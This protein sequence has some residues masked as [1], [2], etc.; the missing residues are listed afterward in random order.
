MTTTKLNLEEYADRKVRVTKR[1]NDGHSGEVLEGKV[2]AAN[3]EKN[4]L[5]LKVK[6][7]SSA[8]LIL[9]FEI[10][11]I[12]SVSS[13]EDDVTQSTLKPVKLNNVRRHL[14]NAH[15][16]GLKQINQLTDD[17]AF[18]QH[19]GLHEGPDAADLGHKHEA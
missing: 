9:G 15:G 5:L 14:V 19:T 10:D 12:E 6:G 13:S 18:V 7:K 4:L 16:W 17:E 2:E 8:I 3:N 11:T 1:G